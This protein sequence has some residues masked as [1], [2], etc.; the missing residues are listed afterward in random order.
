LIDRYFDELVV[1]D[2]H[3]HRKN[4]LK[5]MFRIKTHA[6]TANTLICE[7]IGKK[8]TSPVLIGPDAESYK[9]AERA[10]HMITCEYT[11]LRKIRHSS[12]TVDV[13]MTKGIELKDHHA[14]IV[15]DMIS[16]GST[17]LATIKHL[18]RLRAKKIT[19][20]CVHGIFAEGALAK[21]RKTGATVVATNTIPNKVSKIDVS[22]LIAKAL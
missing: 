9:W 4:S 20:I 12:R 19:C 22:S 3:L 13:K 16:T 7:Y 17:L 11:I 18:K 15:D 2:P 8:I 6:V 10:A 21:L 14:V 5:K 1:V